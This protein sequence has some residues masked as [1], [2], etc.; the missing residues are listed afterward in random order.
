MGTDYVSSL[1]A[2]HY[3]YLTHKAIERKNPRA[4]Q[5]KSSV[6]VSTPEK[7]LKDLAFEDNVALLETI[8]KEYKNRLM[9]LKIVQQ[10]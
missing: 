8:L 4:A 10:Q 1:S 7:R 3:G 5:S 9:P 6:S 2:G